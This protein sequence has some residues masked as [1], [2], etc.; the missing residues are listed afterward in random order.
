MTP[1][2]LV[3]GMMCDARLF[4][5][6]IAAFSGA[7]DILLASMA[8]HDSTPALAAAALATAPP[9]FALAGLSMGGIVA[10]EML[11]QA[12][13]RVERI[14]LLDT[15]PL[16]ETDEVKAK[17]G[18]QMQTVRAGGLE[19]LMRD[20]MAPNYLA[21]PAARPDLIALCV[22]MALTLGPDVF[23]RQSVALRDR[24]DQSDT[25]RAA[26]LPA[27]ILCGREDKLCPVARHRLMQ[28]ML[29]H[30]RLEIVEGCGHLSTLEAPE[31]TN[32][33]LAR[34]LEA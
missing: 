11:R 15:N 34:W 21:D 26:T 17:R 28:D 6:Q 19:T 8:H 4:V 3:P 2:L 24:P 30:A 33:A 23:I 27:L 22:D 13:E 5:P 9:R 16:A 18:P 10:M 12:P 20:A 7:R 14:A 25:L 1:L 31:A 29:P 32:A